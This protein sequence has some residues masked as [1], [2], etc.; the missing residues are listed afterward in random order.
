MARVR[1]NRNGNRRGLK[2]DGF[3]ELGMPEGPG[4]VTATAAAGAVDGVGV[5]G[6]VAMVHRSPW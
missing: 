6:G 2:L 1:K 5:V 4:D 3:F